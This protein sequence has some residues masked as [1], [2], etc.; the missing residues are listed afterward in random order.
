MS[1]MGDIFNDLKDIKR[2]RAQERVAEFEKKRF[3]I[4]DS[5]R[6][7]LDHKRAEVFFSTDASGTLNVKIY[8]NRGVFQHKPTNIQFYPTKG[9]WQ[10]K[11]KMWH[12]GVD[13][14]QTW[15]TRK[16]KAML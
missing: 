6:K 8:T 4:Q 1:D 11:G 12:G 5:I 14:F 13:A 15:I 2:T 10:V 16:L 3:S 9:T 7:V